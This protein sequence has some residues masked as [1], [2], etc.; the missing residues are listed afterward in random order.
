[1]FFF[2]PGLVSVSFRALS[3]PEIIRIARTA[4]LEGIEWGGDVHAPPS[5][6]PETLTDLAAR[7]R[8]AGLLCSS[9]GSYFRLGCQPA[10]EILPCLRA[11]RLL[12]T[13]TV[14]IWAGN[15]GSADLDPEQRRRIVADARD[16]AAA[17]HEQGI[18]LCLECH[19]NT[20]T[21]RTES[22]LAFLQEVDAPNLF[23]YWQPD[24]F[25]SDEE[26]F[27]NARRLSRFTVHLHVFRWR[28]AERFPLRSGFRPWLRFL[29]CFA[30]AP[31]WLLLEFMPD[32]RPESLPGEAACL[33]DLIRT[34][35]QNGIGER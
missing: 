19:G 25:L 35:C 33:R 7:C 14:R 31:H 27:E 22:S 9:Y 26:N 30:D 32:D 21:D 13:D 11:A 17:A 2:R 5:A 6:P 12:G 28:G 34:V 24:Q 23:M 3:A 18:R 15:T 4:G 1:M 20:L 16:V 29:S 10:K 8:D